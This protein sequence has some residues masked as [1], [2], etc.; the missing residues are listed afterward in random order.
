MW[1]KIQPESF[2][3]K[4]GKPDTRAAYGLLA[5]E[6]SFWLSQFQHIPDKDVIFVGLLDLKTDDFVRSVC[7]NN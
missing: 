1:C 4:S 5:S 7:V 3:D 2:S 6:M